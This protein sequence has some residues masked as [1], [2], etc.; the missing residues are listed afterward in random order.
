MPDQSGHLNLRSSRRCGQRISPTRYPA[1]IS[2]NF[3][4]VSARFCPGSFRFRGKRCAGWPG[5]PMEVRVRVDRYRRTKR[6]INASFDRT[7]MH[8]ESGLEGVVPKARGGRRP[9]GIRLQIG[10]SAIAQG[11][12][13]AWPSSQRW[14]NARHHATAVHPSAEILDALANHACDQM[15]KPTTRR[16]LASRFPDAVTLSSA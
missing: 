6:N 14:S 16:R 4:E 11:T 2:G 10:P 3:S 8:G 15:T 5:V 1:R 12:S 13:T 7:E 9:D